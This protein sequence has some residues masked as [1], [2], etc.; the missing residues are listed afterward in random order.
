[1]LQIIDRVDFM[2]GST[3]AVS[4]TGT[5][6]M[7]LSLID[8]QPRMEEPSKP[9]PSSKLVSVRAFTGTVKCF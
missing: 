3:M 9:K 2:N 4:A 8:C 1:M 5:T 6:S 7:S